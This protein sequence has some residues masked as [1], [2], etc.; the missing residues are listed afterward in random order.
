[1]KKMGASDFDEL[2]AFF[3]AMSQKKN[4]IGAST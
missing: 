4:K 1:M 2:V 3:D